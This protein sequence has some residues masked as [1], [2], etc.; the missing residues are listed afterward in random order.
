MLGWRS[1]P[2]SGPFVP[3]ER[4]RD[5]TR[6]VNCQPSARYRI[7]GNDFITSSPNPQGLGLNP[8]LRWRVR[9]WPQ[10]LWEGAVDL[11]G[12]P[13]PYLRTLPD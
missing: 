10:L 12:H 1:F 8:T 7:N 5:Q 9:L 11:E 6:Q 13:P 2:P 4:N 3:L